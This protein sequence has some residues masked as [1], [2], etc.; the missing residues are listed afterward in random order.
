M[1]SAIVPITSVSATTDRFMTSE[2]HSLIVGD[3]VTLTGLTGGAPIVNGNQYVVKAVAGNT[4]T[5]GLAPTKTSADVSSA[6]IDITSNGT[7]GTVQRFVSLVDDAPLPASGDTRNYTII[8]TKGTQGDDATYMLYESDVLA[9]RGSGTFNTIDGTYDATAGD[10][11]HRTVPWDP[12]V[13]EAG[14]DTANPITSGTCLTA[15]DAPNGRPSTSTSLGQVAYNDQISAWCSTCHTR[16]Y[17]STNQNPGGEPSSS[18]DT[19]KTITAVSGNAIT[20]ASNG[21]A[22][23]DIVHFSSTGATDYYVVVAG[24]AFQVSTAL[25]GTPITSPAAVSDTVIRI[26]PFS[27]SSWYFPRN[28]GDLTYKYQHQTTTN[29]ACT[30]CHVGHGTDAKM[31]VGSTSFSNDLPYPDGTAATDGF[32][33]RLLKIDNRGTCQGCHDPTGTSLAGVQLGNPA[34]PTVP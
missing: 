9:A 21:Y 13:N 17:S 4:F 29:R 24:T 22:L 30:T 5:V 26:S 20:V 28:G 3:I 16:Y 14:C 8:Q 10:Y 12:A 18:A 27:A 23:G 19:S 11:F 15:N 7:G 32:N 6:A 25:E 34:T 33:S 2:A 1:T 31:T